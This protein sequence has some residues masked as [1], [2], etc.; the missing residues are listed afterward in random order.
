MIRFLLL[1]PL[2]LS[3]CAA[4]IDTADFK[5]SPPAVLVTIDHAGVR[6]LRADYRAALCSRLNDPARC[7]HVLPR[8][9]GEAAAPQ[10]PVHGTRHTGYRAAFVPGLFAHCAAEAVVPFADVQARLSAKG[11]E[12]ELLNVDGRGSTEHNAQM[13]AREI[14]AM[15]VRSQRMHGTHRPIILFAYSKGLPDVLELV[16][17]HPSARQH[18]AAV[19]SFAGA[20]NGSPLA[21]D[22]LDT[23]RRFVSALPLPGCKTGDGSEIAALQRS[24]RLDWWKH[25]GAQVA[26]L[27]VPFF[28]IAATP[29]AAQVSPVLRGSHATLS[30]I[31]AHNDGQLMAYDAIVPGSALLGYV[32]A[33]HWSIAI[34]LSTQL[35]SLSPLFIDDVPRTELVEAALDVVVRELARRRDATPSKEKP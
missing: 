5:R 16:L 35:P 9:P 26:A 12:A 7:A 20:S 29:N 18:I 32:N 30:R 13:L 15:A 8:Y 19:V 10:A 31:D 14:E 17:N 11:D 23:Y 4:S 34:P 24:V 33:D 1:A 21:D 6:D 25:H 22:H 3:A 27:K 2:L 28:S